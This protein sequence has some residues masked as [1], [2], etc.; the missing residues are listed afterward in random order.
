MPA[1][2]IDLMLSAG[3]GATVLLVE[4]DASLRAVMTRSLEY[5]G[6]VVHVATSL[7][8]VR[9]I[10]AAT[11]HDIALVDVML[12]D[13]SG[14]E[15]A[16]HLRATRD[17]PI[18]FVTARD[19]IDDRLTGFALGGDDYVT[20]PFSVTELIARVGAVLR[21]AREQAMSEDDELAVADLRLSVAAHEVRRGDRELDLSPTEFRLLHLLMSHARQVL[22]KDQI[23][24]SVW[25][26]E[27]GDTGIVEKFVS[28][29]RRKVDDG[30]EPLIQTV[31]GFGYVLRPA[32]PGAE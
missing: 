5:A 4:D 22:S 27:V 18:I 7:A 24:A 11:V 25:G 30:D 28:Q 9:A 31:R 6:Y 23:L 10:P 15:L 13:G 29:L 14:L 17:L 1:R 20:K 3:G 8:D 2:Q 21:R 19:S 16:G 26:Y 32:K 12:P